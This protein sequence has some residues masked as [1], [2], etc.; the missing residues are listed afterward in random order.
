MPIPDIDDNYTQS[1]VDYLSGK[2][3]INRKIKGKGYQIILSISLFS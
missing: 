3:A 2:P 1:L